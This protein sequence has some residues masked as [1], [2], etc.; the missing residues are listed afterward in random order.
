MPTL[1]EQLTALVAS[2][3]S[4]HGNEA[5]LRSMRLE[6]ATAWAEA[7]K[8]QAVRL[9][10][11]EL[12]DACRIIRNSGIRHFE[13][14]SD[15]QQAVAPWRA[16]LQA[17]WP[18][19][20]LGGMLM[21]CSLFYPLHELGIRAELEDTPV[22]ML[23]DYL[24]LLFEP[25]TLLLSP[26]ESQRYARHLQA[27][28]NSFAPAIDTLG[29]AALDMVACSL[30]VIQAYFNDE[31]LRDLMAARARVLECYLRKLGFSLEHT[32]APRSQRERNKLRLGIL[33]PAMGV[34]SEGVYALPHIMGLDRN[35]F[36]II[37][38]VLKSASNPVE[39]ICRAHS[40]GFVILP[41]SIEQQVTRIRHDELD[42]ALFLTNI[43]AVTSHMALL[44][45]H[46]LAR[47]QIAS[48]ASP[49]TTGFSQIDYYLSSELNDLDGA[50]D[51]Y[52]EKLCRIP[53]SLN[54]YQFIDEPPSMEAPTRADLGIAHQTVVYFS[55]LNFF[56][57]LPELAAQWAQILAAVPD[58]ILML[59][60]FNLNW[61]TH[62]PE[63]AFRHR[64]TRDMAA[65]GVDPGRIKILSPVPSRGDV[66]NLIRLADVYLDGYPFA[67]A[68]SI[69]DPL[70]VGIPAVAREGTTARS[71]HG[72]IMLRMFGL[73]DLVTNRAEDYV[74]L[75]VKLGH[76][77]TLR[78]HLQKQMREHFSEHNPILDSADFGRRLTPILKDLAKPPT[79]APTLREALL[80]RKPMLTRRRLRS[81]TDLE[82]VRSV[83]L[84]CFTASPDNKPL[85]LVDVGA[86]YGQMA[87]PFLQ[88]GWTADLFEPDPSCQ[89]VLGRELQVY[90]KQIKIHAMA[91]SDEEHPCIDFY[92][93]SSD[94]LSGLSPSPYGRTQNILQVP[95]V[96]LGDY[97]HTLSASQVDFLKIDTEGQD[98]KVLASHDFKTLAPRFVF[99]EVNTEFKEHSLD[100]IHQAFRMME[101]HGYRALILRYEDDGTFKQGIW[102]RYWLKEIIPPEDLSAEKVPL[103]GNVIFY[104]Q[105]DQMFL[106]RF[107]QSIDQALAS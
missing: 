35:Q 38:Y 80:S 78:L 17:H 86:C 30:N 79:S 101:G 74:H 44:G 75:A 40:D 48:M 43:A 58:S 5:E 6:L 42:L 14:N 41:S 64:L 89:A 53:G 84:P 32:F 98:L 50:A 88:A 37:L 106:D 54:H 24:Q 62:Y 67:G 73:H 95:V 61:G 22:W 90:A 71:R 104:H 103:L 31:N 26:G 18:S 69:Y 3:Q 9:C 72:A 49:V 52:T 34:Q 8:E 68:C 1:M 7:D 21:A 39:E 11:T 57:I 36:E 63:Y 47:V 15:E 12:L 105:Q 60:P 19:P 28:L 102:D 59:L 46:R 20:D 97:L 66:L 16:T 4:K 33:A 29:M 76:E 2:F 77:K 51:H 70:Q 91:V 96:R 55:A 99:I 94:G 25:P 107:I 93:A 23:A 83:V 100:H 45:A 87:S 27:A 82:L 92:K 85:H 10:D 56:K 13:L 65:H 81:F